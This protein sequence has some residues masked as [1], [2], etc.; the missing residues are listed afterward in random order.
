[1][2]RKKIKNKYYLNPEAVLDLHGF[3]KKEAERAFFEFLEES[4]EKGFRKIKIITGQGWHNK[5]FQSILKPFIEDLLDKENYSYTDAKIND[6]GRGA[7][8]VNL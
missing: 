1:M 2:K 7:L 5:D 4:Q 6:G 3:T 8:I